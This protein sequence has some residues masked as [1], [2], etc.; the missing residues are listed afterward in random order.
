MWQSRFI[1]SK[2]IASRRPL[3]NI[4]FLSLP[5]MWQ[6]RF[7]PSKHIAS[8]RPLPNIFFLS[9]PLMWQSRFTPSKH[10]ASRRPLPNIFV[11]W[12]YSWPSSLKTSSLFKPSFSFFPLLLF[13]PPFPL[14]FGILHRRLGHRLLSACKTFKL[15]DSGALLVASSQRKNKVQNRTSLNFV[16]GRDFLVVHL[17]P[18]ED[19]TLLW[20]RDSFLLFHAL[21]DPLDFV[22][23]FNV[24]LNF[25]SSQSLHLDQHLG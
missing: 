18:G 24:N 14:F 13:F 3:P 16:V 2:H 10:I 22:S 21:L 6:S 9:L 15:R 19:E 12:A 17:L 11:T 7:I 23:G 8:R 4:F 5:L 20:R 25:F 1:P